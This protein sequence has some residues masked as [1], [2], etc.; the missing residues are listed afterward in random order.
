MGQWK[1]DSRGGYRRLP[2]RAFQLHQQ[3]RFLLHLELQRVQWGR[4]SPLNL[5]GPPKAQLG[6]RVLTGRLQVHLHP[7]KPLLHQEASFAQHRARRQDLTEQPS[8]HEHRYVDNQRDL[9][10][11][12]GRPIPRTLNNRT[13][14][15]SRF[16]PH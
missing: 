8:L 5:P 1:R 3:P 11:L 14:D 15:P 13:T 10:L 2:T 6:I 4:S 16:A 7:G 12:Q 9:P